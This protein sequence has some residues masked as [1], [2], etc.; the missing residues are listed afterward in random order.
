MGTGWSP[1]G[2]RRGLAVAAALPGGCHQAV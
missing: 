1:A 2:A